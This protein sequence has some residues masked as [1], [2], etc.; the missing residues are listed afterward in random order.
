MDNDSATE[1]VSR[2]L[3]SNV[4]YKVNGQ[5]LTAK[6]GTAGD[7]TIFGNKAY[8]AYI[9]PDSSIG[10]VADSNLGSNGQNAITYGL[11]GPAEFGPALLSLNNTLY[12]FYLSSCCGNEIY[13]QTSTDGLNWSAASAVFS[14]YFQGGSFNS[15]SWAT[16]PAAVAWNGQPIL[17]I[18]TQNG[19]FT[20]ALLQ[21]NISGTSGSGP[22]VPGYWYPETPARPSVTI[23]NGALYLAWVDS[24]NGNQV[25]LMHYT[26]A[27]G[28]SGEILT[29]KYGIPGIHPL[30]AGAL[31]M[32][33]RNASNAHIYSTFTSDGVTF[34]TPQEDLASTTNRQPVPFSNWNLSSNWTFYVGQNNDLFTVLE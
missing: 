29:G 22:Y 7:A 11:P 5:T 13:M 19:G 14:L 10:I 33:Y 17:Y 27:S 4:P 28:W 31:Q 24:E 12:L 3:L 8:Y 30:A 26:S 18:G 23:W 16:P 9:R 2:D 20:D 25:G 15:N 32:V 34:S 6:A 1:T 21:F